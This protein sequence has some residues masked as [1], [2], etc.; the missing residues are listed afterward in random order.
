MKLTEWT[1]ISKDQRCFMLRI[2]S[3]DMM[4]MK[5][6]PEIDK[7]MISMCEDSNEIHKILLGLAVLVRNIE[8]SNK[9]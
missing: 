4:K 9:P 6:I 5:P 2:D 7:F 8:E 3:A 1:D